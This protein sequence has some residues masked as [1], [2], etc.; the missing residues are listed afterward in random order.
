[1]PYSEYNEKMCPEKK[2]TS[3]DFAS[4]VQVESTQEADQGSK[5]LQALSMC[6]QAKGRRFQ[7]FSFEKC[8]SASSANTFEAP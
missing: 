7:R 5:V 2:D 6:I 8:R 3:R 1:M 4:G